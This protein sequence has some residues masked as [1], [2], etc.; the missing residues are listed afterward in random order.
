MHHGS[1]SIDLNLHALALACEHRGGDAQLTSGDLTL[2]VGL[3]RWGLEDAGA[4]LRQ[5]FDRELRRF[6]P[7]A[8]FLVWSR[9]APAL[10]T[11]QF[12]ELMAV[13]GLSRHDPEVLAAMLPR[14]DALAESLD[15]GQVAALI[16]ILAHTWANY[17]PLSGEDVDLGFEIGTLLYRCRAHG[18][19]LEYLHRSEVLHGPSVGGLYNRALC[20]R[21]LGRQAESDALAEHLAGLDPALAAE[22]RDLK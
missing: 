16:E 18:E 22:L 21:M 7:G 1:F 10:S 13:L 3:F 5:A 17:F 11:M 20:L 14:L 12:D 9:L 15:P 4:A 2:Q 6:G 19:A 8:W